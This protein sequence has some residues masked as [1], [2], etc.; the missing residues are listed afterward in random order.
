MTNTVLSYKASPTGVLY[1][2]S[3]AFVKGIMGPFGSG[4]S[5]CVCWDIFMRMKKQ[6]PGSDGI[7]RTR[8]IIARNT[9]NE[10]ETTTM[11][12]WKD[13]FPENTFGHISRKPPYRQTIKYDD[14]E[15]E[16]IFLALDKPED[17]KKLLSFEVTGIWFNEA[18]QIPIELINAALGRV[19]RY[20]PRKDK[21]DT[22][23]SDQWPTW[24]GILMDTNPPDDEH[25]YYKA[26]EDDAWAV[27]DAGEPVDPKSIPENRRWDFFKQ[28]SGLA[29]NAENIENLPGGREYYKRM[30]GG[31]NTK[32]WVDVHVH[33]NYGFIKHG[34][35]VFDGYWNPD[36][37]VAK[38]EL[39]IPPGGKIYVGIDASGR[40]PAS[41][42]A[43]KTALGQ[44][45]ILKELCITNEAGMGAVD[46]ANLLKGVVAEDF[47]HHDLYIWGDP[48]GDWKQQTDE[49]TYF[50]ILRANG[51]DI[52]APRDLPQN[53]ISIR[54]E[55]VKYVMGRMVQGK[56]ALYVSPS[57][58]QLLRGFNGGYTYKTYSSS[59]PEKCKPLKNRYSDVQDALQYMLVGAGEFKTLK[60]GNRPK[61]ME[62]IVADTSFAVF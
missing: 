34:S 53:R 2:L 19:G 62:A 31:G 10:L 14:V 30:L 48:A 6:A 33:G 35:P 27:N 58:K 15:A 46:Y 25:W 37:M 40:H 47:P 38:N 26:A 11:E 36:V 49:R 57:C 21:P 3:N 28:P 59:E 61:L 55:T 4:K 12:T 50:D 51:I 43:H 9:F 23:P 54:L 44:W 45:Q 1:H 60:R 16:V 8:W 56:P 5:V 17:Q 18:R 52:R 20:P 13:W 24:S 7:R 32:E 41:V 22:V 39:V 42:F 29:D